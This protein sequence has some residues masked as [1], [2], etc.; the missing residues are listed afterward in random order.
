[1]STQ[2]TGVAQYL[3]RDRSTTFFALVRID[4]DDAIVELRDA[5]GVP[6][7]VLDRVAH[8]DVANG[9]FQ[10]H[11]AVVDSTTVTLASSAK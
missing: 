4:R 11:D 1:M 7:D 5:G 10:R 2:R 9:A 3:V 8:V 6:H